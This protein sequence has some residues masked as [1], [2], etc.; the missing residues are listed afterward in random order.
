[1]ENVKKS[2]SEVYDVLVRELKRQRETVELIAS[3][4]ITSQ[5][6]METQG[7]CLTNKYAEGYSSIV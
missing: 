1:M 5:A 2:D 3:E 7:S 6:V 4:N